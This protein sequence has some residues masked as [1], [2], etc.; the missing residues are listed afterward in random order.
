VAADFVKIPASW[1]RVGSRLLL[2]V[3][4][5]LFLKRYSFRVLPSGQAVGLTAMD[6]CSSGTWARE[7]VVIKENQ[8]IILFLNNSVRP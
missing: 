3:L 5:F 4:F 1:L 6:N 8:T 2:N 7:L